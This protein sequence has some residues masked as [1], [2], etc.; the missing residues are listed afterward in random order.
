MK[1]RDLIIELRK[2]GVKLSIRDGEL[3][4]SA[5]K[6]V[7]TPEMR[8][9]LSANKEALLELLSAA[10][11][12]SRPAAARIPQADRTQPIPLSYAQKRMW[13]L[14]E[15]E[16]GTSIYNISW[17]M[18]LRGALNTQALESAI[19]DLVMRHESLRTTFVAQ[20]GEPAQVIA[21]ELQL[22]LE[23]AIM[24]G[25]DDDALQQQLSEWSK[26]SFD[27]ASGPLLKVRLVEL[28][29][30]DHVLMMVMHHIVSDAWSL[31]VLQREFVD[32]YLARSKGETA[33]LENLP[34]QF[35]D[36]AVWQQGHL[37]E[38]EQARQLDYWKEQL[39]GA[40][41]VLELPTDRQRPSEQSY[42]G[43][44][45]RRLM[46]VALRD[47]L[48]KLARE[49]DATLFMVL[50]AAFDVLLHRYS[51]Q[52][53]IVVGTPIAGR[54]RSEL[55]G[56]IGLF[57]NTI[58]MRAQ[59]SDGGSFTEL[60]DQVQATSMDAFAHQ[61][62]PFEKLVDEL[63]PERDMSYSPVFQVLFML[64]NAP[65]TGGEPLA[66]LQI[67]PV[68]F[69]YGTAKFDLTLATGETPDGLVAE[70]EYSTD[71]FDAPTIERMLEHYE[72]L[73]TQIVKN[74]LQVIDD[75]DLL[76]T[77]EREQ[78]LTDWNATAVDYPAD[79]TL[80]SLLEQQA[81]ATPNAEALV[82]GDTS[83]S[84]AELN[85]RANGLAHWLID[86]GTQPDDLVGVCMERSVEMVVALLGIVKAG[87]AYVPFDPDYPAQR[88]EHM[89][90]DAELKVLLAQSGVQDAL[91]AHSVPVLLLDQ[92]KLDGQPGDN[93]P[94]RALPHHAAYVIF[95][96]GSTGRPKGVVNEHRGI[97][98]RLLW[99]QD[100]Y[101]LNGSDRVLQKTPFS[102]DVS[103]WEFFWPL[104]SGAT[105]VV[106][107]P[108][109]HKDPA[110][111]AEL[112]NK[113]RITTLHFVPSMLQVFLADEAAGGCDSLH[114]VICSGE[115]LSHDLQARF[116]KM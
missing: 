57:L 84:Y 104:I 87:L 93:P 105:L 4:I 108:G 51:G 114:R 97:V 46:P 52:D 80:A 23:R 43:A 109:G 30:D 48:K 32:F 116:Y 14:E 113:E 99:M 102:F 71:L 100:E 9:R 11:G 79:A 29:P 101:Q 25:A 77:S 39:V 13:F 50:L 28:A 88:L 107:K 56:L 64:Q 81:A 35:A 110:Y 37:N 8:E 86:Q 31:D 70:I 34:V 96:S 36:Y 62:L 15:F 47:A 92:V 66:G 16:G 94:A 42:R 103:V 59:L 54:Q 38:T 55:E 5:P 76:S 69:E 10:D 112:I 60:L 3:R 111:L 1:T 90:E 98:N 53:D 106:A 74:P 83:L 21:D 78:L 44:R 45:L 95:T 2:Q 24:P 17:A 58:V 68:E 65:S 61:D 67:E 7:M 89:L 72:L 82:C 26:Q 27:L 63:A 19:N 85:A 91:P 12:A 18:R 22:P 20:D 73:L 49:R 40:P 41:T 6:G 115:A 75:I 33:Q